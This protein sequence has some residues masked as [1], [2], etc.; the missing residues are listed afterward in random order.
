MTT[1]VSEYFRGTTLAEAKRLNFGQICWA[2]G[3]YLADKITTLELVDYNPKNER[4]NRYAVAQPQQTLLF[5]HTPVHELHLEHNEEM[6][7]VKAKKRPFI[8]ASQSPIEWPPG[9]RRLKEKGFVCLPIYSFH[10][11]D[12][13]EFRERIAAMEYPWWIYLPEDPG[14]MRRES[15]IRLDRLQVIEKNHIE[16]TQTALTEDSWFFISE[17][18]RY[19]LTNQIEDVFMD[20][21][22]EMMSKLP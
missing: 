2:P 10:P 9:A 6:L 7:V 12:T 13:P 17:W 21:R 22:K 8:I 20:E 19:Y 14:Q 18:L 3:Y 15:F 11:E 1:L 16:P 5:N 4:L